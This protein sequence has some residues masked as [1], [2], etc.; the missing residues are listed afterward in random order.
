[1]T[2]L[3]NALDNGGFEIID[4]DFIYLY[5]DLD[6]PQMPVLTD[7]QYQ[8]YCNK[9]NGLTQWVDGKFVYH[10]LIID[11]KAFLAQQK[12]QLVKKLADKI[13]NFKAQLLV[14]YPQAEI[15]SFFRQEA[16]A[17]AY[18]ADNHAPTPMLT[19]IAQ[20]R[21]V[22]L[23]EL[24]VKVLE[25]SAQFSV[26]MGAIIGVRQGFEDRILAAQDQEALEQIEKEVHAWQL[27]I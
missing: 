25:K 12:N 17:L 6:L 21:G 10:D 14:G 3:I 13:D 20:N 15:D 16:E 1:M 24:V 26:A 7:E 8:E 4:S 23:G 2:Y 19:Q 22:A 18:Q 5:P 11:K 27:S 9:S